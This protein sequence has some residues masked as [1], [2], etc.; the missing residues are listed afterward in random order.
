MLQINAQKGWDLSLDGTALISKKLDSGTSN[1]PTSPTM[2]INEH[3]SAVP[4]MLG[5]SSDGPQMRGWRKENN[6]RMGIS[7]VSQVRAGIWDIGMGLSTVAPN[8]M[9][10]Q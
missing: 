6:I 8:P 9:V 2:A 7:R 4:F 10:L 5:P 1:R 3:S